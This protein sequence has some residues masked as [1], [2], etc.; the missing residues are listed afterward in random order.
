[1]LELKERVDQLLGGPSAREVEDFELSYKGLLQQSKPQQF[2][3][4]ARPSLNT[5]DLDDM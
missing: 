4:P 2:M 3:A 5:E 1:M